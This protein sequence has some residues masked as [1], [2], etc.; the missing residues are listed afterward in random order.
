MTKF[1]SFSDISKFNPDTT[2]YSAANALVLA[3]AARLAYEDKATAESVAKND[4]KLGNFAF[5]GEHGKSTQAIVLGNREFLITAF[6][7]TQ[8]KALQDW[9]TDAKFIAP[10]KVRSGKVHRGFLE[11]LQK[12][13]PAIIPTAVGFDSFGDSRIGESLNRCSFQKK[14]RHRWLRRLRSRGRI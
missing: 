3:D 6:R 2:R 13:W 12:V 11:G 1:K 14:E 10:R 4:W 9:I 5:F 8:P 7:G